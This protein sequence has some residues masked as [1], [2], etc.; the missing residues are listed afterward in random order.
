MKSF[1][2]F[3]RPNCSDNFVVG[4]FLERLILIHHPGE[5]VHLHGSRLHAGNQ[6]DVQLLVP[7]H[8]LLPF[9][10]AHPHLPLVLLLPG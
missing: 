8:L 7:F 1:F 10:D 2:I 9:P 4:L 5:L 3:K 6:V